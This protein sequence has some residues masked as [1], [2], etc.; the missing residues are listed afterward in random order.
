MSATAW[1]N[2]SFFWKRLA[3]GKIDRREERAMNV[4]QMALLAVAAWVGADA[5][6]VGGWVAT[7][8]LARRRRPRPPFGRLLSP[9]PGM[10]FGTSRDGADRRPYGV[11]G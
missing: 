7:V 3:D 8:G 10:T 1:R 5:V 6:I 11:A 4:T 9:R 2:H